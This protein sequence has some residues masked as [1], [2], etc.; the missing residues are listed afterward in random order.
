MSKFIIQ[1]NGSVYG[2]SASF[3]ALSFCQH[4]LANGHDIITVF[5]YQDGVTNSNALTCPASD[6][7]DMHAKWQAFAQQYNITLTNCVS[8]ALRRG[9]L[10]QQEAVE[11]GKKHWNSDETFTMGGLGELVVG[12]EKADRLISF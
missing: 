1:V 10:S 11:N 6:E 2:T 12:I 3:R 4:A 8:A 7:I 9:V 5:F